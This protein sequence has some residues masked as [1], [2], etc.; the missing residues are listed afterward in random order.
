MSGKRFKTE[1]SSTSTSRLENII[2]LRKFLAKTS[3]LFS[4]GQVSSTV[5]PCPKGLANWMHWV[6]ASIWKSRT[7]ARTWMGGQTYSQ[8]G[9][10]IHACKSQKVVNSTHIQLTCDQLVSKRWK[11]CVEFRTNLSSTK[12][13]ASYRMRKSTQVGGQTKSKL[14]ANRNLRWLASTWEKP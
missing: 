14:N 13:N 4:Y 9:S 1:W 3:F 5:K 11:T 2:I 10:Q 6:N 7:C 12:V 8:V